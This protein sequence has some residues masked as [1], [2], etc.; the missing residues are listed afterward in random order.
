MSAYMLRIASDDIPMTPRPNYNLIFA[1]TLASAIF[2]SPKINTFTSTTDDHNYVRF[3]RSVIIIITT[4]C[5]KLCWRH[6]ADMLF[7]SSTL[8]AFYIKTDGHDSTE[9]LFNVA[10]DTHN[11]TNWIVIIISHLRDFLIF[12]K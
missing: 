8:V 7:S 2:I 11:P 4:I 12:L 10:N 1:L 9:I 5:E 6:E 3:P